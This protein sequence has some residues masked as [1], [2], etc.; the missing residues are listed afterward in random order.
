M[1]IRIR[2]P[3]HDPIKMRKKI[4]Y[5]LELKVCLA[6]GSGSGFGSL[7]FFIKDMKEI[8][9][10]KEKSLLLKNT[11]YTIYLLYIFCYV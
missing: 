9:Y 3:N 7:L 6:T 4:R 2:N 8:F 5:D 11:K 1:R 10:R